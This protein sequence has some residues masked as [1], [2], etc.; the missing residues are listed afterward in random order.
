MPLSILSQGTQGLLLWL[1]RFIIGY[2]RHYE[3]PTNFANKPAILIID[4]IDAHLHPSWQRRIL[5]ELTAEFPTLQIFCSTQSPLMLAGLGRGQ[6]QLLKRAGPHRIVVSRNET[7]IR[8]W[9]ADEIYTSFM[10]VEHPTDMKTDQ[11]LDR[12]E[13]LRSVRNLSVGQKQELTRLRKEVGSVLMDT[14]H[15]EP[16]ASKEKDLESAAERL[17]TRSKRSVRKKT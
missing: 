5:P 13:E 10:E 3:F 8:G 4:E 9:S 1:T 17:L 16:A 7:D 6:V 2:A 15:C 11:Q 12:L 14:P